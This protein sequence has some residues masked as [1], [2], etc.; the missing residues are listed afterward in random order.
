MTRLS[1]WIAIFLGLIVAT[2]WVMC[3]SWLFWL[4]GAKNISSKFNAFMDA[5]VFDK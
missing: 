2:I 3:F 1:L 5:V 4:L